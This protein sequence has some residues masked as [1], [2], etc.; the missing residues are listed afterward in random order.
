MQAV[1]LVENGGPL[2]VGQIPLPQPGPGQ[3]LIHMAASP[4]NP[5]DL[6]FLKGFYGV[7]KP[8]PIVPGFEGSGTVIAAGPGLLPL[9]WLN[10]TK[11]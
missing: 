8:F 4:I 2:T 5:S 1:Q 6:G 11:K 10:E 9:L 3:V 7:Q